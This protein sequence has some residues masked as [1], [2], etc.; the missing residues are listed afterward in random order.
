MSL[1]YYEYKNDNNSNFYSSFINTLSLELQTY[2]NKTKTYYSQYLLHIKLLMNIYINGIKQIDYSYVKLPINIKYQ[3]YE[4]I[5]EYNKIM[6]IYETD[7]KR[8]I[9]EENTI[10]FLLETLPA[11]IKF[12]NSDEMFMYFNKKYLFG[13]KGID[14]KTLY[15]LSFMLL[16]TGKIE[17]YFILEQHLTILPLLFTFYKS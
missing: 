15:N 4:R 9:G 2:L 1:V 10:I 3:I 17:E 16:T 6:N 5:I 12:K 11:E 14:Q 13:K 7:I 8:F